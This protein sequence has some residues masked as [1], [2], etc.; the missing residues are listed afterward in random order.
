M[1]TVNELLPNESQ[2]ASCQ[3]PLSLATCVSSWSPV[4]LESTED[5]RTWLQ[6]DSLANPSPLQGSEQEPTT[7]AICGPQLSTPFARYDPDTAS[8]KTFQG[9]LL[10]D[11]SIPL[12]VILPKAGMTVDGVCYRQLSW[13]LRIRET[14]FGLLP[15]PTAQD[16]LNRT[17]FNPILT[18]NGTIR[19]LNKAGGQSRASLSA[20]AHMWPT[21]KAKQRG[22]CPAERARKSPSLESAVM[23][24]TPQSR[25]YRTGEA[26]RWDDMQ[27]SRNLNDQ[28]ATEGNGGKLNPAWV[29]WLMG[30]PLGWTDLNPLAMDKFRQWQQQ[31]GI[32]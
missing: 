11:I 21:P 32:Y 6:V 12:S 27:R 28:V 14:D 19:H 31:H 13:E 20:V 3:A 17:V 9:L 15:T 26:H 7:H 8:W 1:I 10:L 24:A 2:T 30:W 5:L 22:D 16:A 29:E 18:S 25:D 4:Q 23:M